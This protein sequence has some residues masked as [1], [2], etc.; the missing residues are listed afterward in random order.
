MTTESKRPS[1]DQLLE[2]MGSH[3]SVRVFRSGEP[4]QPGELDDGLIR[5]SVQAAQMASTSSHIQAYSLIRVRNGAKRERLAELTGG[6]PQVAQA[7]A[8]FVICGEVR[9]HALAAER[10]GSL[11][12][13][14]LESFLLAVIDASLFAEK[15]VLALEGH[16]LGICYTGG[17]RDNLN[18]VDELLD[19]PEHVYP[20]FGLCAGV[21]VDLADDDPRK[22]VPKPRLPVDAVLFDDRYPSD[23]AMLA[24]MDKHDAEMAEYYNERGRPGH[25][26]TGG[27]VRRMAKPLRQELSAYYKSK[28]ARLE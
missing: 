28:G 5:R 23:V 10:A 22:P 27:L 12:A 9:R 1:P 25:N 17:L 21:P 18:Q 7:G 4:G 15:L 11:M 8:F 2:L 14:N 19:I 6:Q 24:M 16:G 3:T 20:L 13:R 26:W